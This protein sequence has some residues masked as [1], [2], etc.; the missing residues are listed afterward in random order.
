MF[1]FFSLGEIYDFNAWWK[2]HSKDKKKKDRY[3]PSITILIAAFNEDQTIKRCLDSIAATTYSNY[4]VI[5]VNDGSS[6]ATQK[7]VSQWKKKHP[8]ITLRLLYQKNKGKAHALNNALSKVTSKLVMTL[9]ADSDLDKNALTNA[10][11]YFK[12]RQVVALAANIRIFSTKTLLGLIQVIEYLLGHRLKKAYTVLNN[13]YIIGGIG[14]VYRTSIIKKINAYDT[15]TM[16]EDIDLS[17][18]ILQ[19]GNRKNK[20]IFAENVICSTEP[21]PNI[22]DF[23]RQRLRWKYGRMQTLVKNKDLFFK[24]NTKFNKRLTWLQ[25]PYVIF[26]EL[27]F[28]I[29]PLLIIFVISI[30][31]IYKDFSSFQGMLFFLG[32]YT[33]MTIIN[34]KYLSNIEK[35]ELVIISPLAYFFFFIVSVVEYIA[36]L[37]CIVSLPKILAQKDADCRWQHVERIGITS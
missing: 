10:V 4:S 8:N 21:V 27:S 31:I 1:S 26:S 19:K 30:S 2:T 33:A 17:M 7:V 34:D 14:A 23:F 3:K 37:R 35:I 28:L 12:D 6:D 13:E 20:L 32:F 36:L 18:K 24:K 29:D 9:D 5:V 16:T 22:R 25:L 11:T 15:D